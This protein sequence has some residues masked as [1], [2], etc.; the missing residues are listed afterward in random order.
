MTLPRQVEELI[1]GCIDSI[2]T[3]EILLLLQRSPDTFW[4]P[5]A[6]GSHLGMGEGTAEKR[7]AGLLGRE[8][9]TK[10]TSGGY[11]YTPKDDEVR[12]HVSALAAAYAEQRAAVVNAVFGENLTRIRA[13]ADAFKVNE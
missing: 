3:L 5:A 10:G 6:V 4:R 11:R 7:L 12:E 1:A 8:L 13:F 9:V 2:E